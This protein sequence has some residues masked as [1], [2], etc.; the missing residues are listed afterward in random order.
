MKLQIVLF[1]YA[2]V[3]PATYLCMQREMFHILEHKYPHTGRQKYQLLHNCFYGDADI[4][5]ARSKVVADFLKNGADVLVMIDHD[6]IWRP[7]DLLHI[8]LKAHEN[9]A[10]VGGMVSKRSVGSGIASHLK[11]LFDPAWLGT[12]KLLP[13]EY[14]G[15]GMMAVTREIC[16]EVCAFPECRGD[17]INPFLQFFDQNGIYMSED[18]AFSRRAQILGFQ[19]LL[20]SFPV[21]GHV[22]NYVYT[23]E[24][25]APPEQGNRSQTPGAA[26]APGQVDPLAPPPPM[27]PEMAR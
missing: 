24:T 12:D 16:E 19:T 9:R 21:T 11:V 10:I 14:V 25:A 22:G 13:T 18:W 6:I 23:V 3:E 20:S 5:R 27:P 26:A 15:A 4:G 17:W 8:A 7:G 2:G 1:G